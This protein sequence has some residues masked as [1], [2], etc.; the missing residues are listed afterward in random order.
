MMGTVKTAI[1][2]DAELF[3]AAE[4]LAGALNISRSR[5]VALAV[6]EYVRR[7]QNASLLDRLNEAYADGDG[8]DDRD[9]VRRMRRHHAAV[10]AADRP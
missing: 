5:L 10:I 3:Q 4:A 9:R 1:S 6:E 7:H 2:L 8:E